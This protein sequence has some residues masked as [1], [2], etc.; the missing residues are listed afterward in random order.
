MIKHALKRYYF[1]RERSFLVKEEDLVSALKVLNRRRL[2][3]EVK[4]SNCGGM[5]K[6]KWCVTAKATATEWA[7]IAGIFIKEGIN[8]Y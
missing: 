2:A 3:I 8:T 7:A 6:D 5:E 4:V 1:R